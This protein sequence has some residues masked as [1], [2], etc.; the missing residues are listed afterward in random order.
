MCL[1]R[2]YFFLQLCPDCSPET[3]QS[4][5]TPRCPVPTHGIDTSGD[6]VN[7]SHF[8]LCAVTPEKGVGDTRH[9]L[10]STPLHQAAQP[11]CHFGPTTSFLVWGPS[12]C[13]DRSVPSPQPALRATRQAHWAGGCR[14]WQQETA[15][16]SRHQQEPADLSGLGQEGAGGV[17]SGNVP[18][19]GSVPTKKEL[20]HT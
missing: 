11:T 5:P 7:A 20:S 3:L 19:G 13:P 6:T 18:T 14:L 4:L 1:G 10:P 15:P 12:Q 9:P 17:H 8:Y 2:S 16:H